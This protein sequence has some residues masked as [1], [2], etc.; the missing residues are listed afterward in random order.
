MTEEEQRIKL[1]RLRKIRRGHCSVLTKLTREVE[2]LVEAT[3]PDPNRA[4]RL[5]IIHEQLDGKMKVFSNLDGE[6]VS[7]CAEEDIDQEI[8][9]SETIIAKI[10]EAKRKIDF[11]VKE[12]SHDRARESTTPV[13]NPV[14]K[15]RLPELTLPKF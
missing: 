7:L 13:S 4:S 2:G 14:A 15:P 8:D 3:E 12:N 6:I 1:D 10:I 5:R 11:T 9:D